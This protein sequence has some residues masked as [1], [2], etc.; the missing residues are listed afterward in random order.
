[1]WE[2]ITFEEA[3]VKRG[4]RMTVVSGVPSPWGEAAKGIFHVKGLEWSAVRL[5]PS[6][7]QLVEWSLSKSAP[8]VVYDAEPP[9]SD[10]RE[11]LLL[12][13]RLQPAP[14]LLPSD[15]ADRANAFELAHLLCGQE[16]LGWSRR[17]WLT[18]LGLKG[19]GG[20][21]EPVAQYL[22]KKYGYSEQAGEAARGRVIEIL[23]VFSDRLAAQRANGHAYLFDC[24]MTVVDIYVATFAGLL[25]PL[26]DDVCFMKPATRAAFSDVDDETREAAE[27]LLEH[28]DLMYERW[29]E[30]VLRL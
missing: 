22:A 6:N 19:E 25:Q 21:V 23:A 9:R 14:S 5:D 29:L 8:S 12:A 2:F 3:V 28:R 20:F 30:P 18:H 26:P 11:I 13:E 17:L 10:W 24:G 15:T 1:M 7:K 27:G 16:G 4:L